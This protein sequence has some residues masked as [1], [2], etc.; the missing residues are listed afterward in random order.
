[1]GVIFAAFHRVNEL[2]NDQQS[3][4]AG[5]VVDVLEALV[6]NAPVAGGEHLHLIPQVFNDTGHQSKVD[7]QH[8]GKEDGIFLLHFP[9]KQEA[10]GFV[11]Y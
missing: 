3:G 7:R 11:I 2:S 4:I 8:G 9:G 1:M 6:H 10:A 5:V